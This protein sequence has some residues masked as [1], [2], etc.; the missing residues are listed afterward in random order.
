METRYRRN[1]RLFVAYRAGSS[2]LLYIAIS[3]P[4]YQSFGLNLAQ[5]G[6]AYAINGLTVF[7]FDIP[8]GFVADR[9]GYR[10][11][12]LI[13][14]AL[15]ALG[16]GFLAITYQ[17]WLAYLLQVLLGMGFAI[18]RN[19]DSALA[20]HSADTI[21]A[22]FAPYA[23]LGVAGMGVAEGLASLGTA[24][25]AW[26][27]PGAAPRIAMG[28]QAVVYML[29]L[30]VPWRMYEPR[31]KLAKRLV[32]VRDF[33]RLVRSDLR[34]LGTTVWSEVRSNKEVAW[35]LLYGATIG[36]TTQTVVNLVQPYFQELRL[37]VWQF[38]LWW[39]VYHLLWAACS[40]LSGP[41]EKWL[42]R[43]GAL[44]SLVGWGILTNTAM[45]LMGGTAGL[46]IMVAFYFIRG[47]QMPIIQD[48]MTGVVSQ[49]RRATLLGVM[50]SVQFA[51]YSGM[52]L[53][54]GYIAQVGSVRM[55]FG[56]SAAIYGTLGL[57]FI[58]LLRRRVSS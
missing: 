24:A 25:L 23:R 14:V 18:A 34:A 4:L 47:I 30:I 53:I 41:Y 33:G 31:P 9:Y 45:A 52:N 57:A 26:W 16:F 36:C 12:L 49:D 40:L 13:G 7:L 54:L 3:L 51:M 44:A 58:S 32:T 55:A 48:Y 37:E 2:I 56:V 46:L 17:P 29:L 42:G 21:G 22:A 5:I 1:L 10:R 27:Q 11:M 19:A 50:T 39:A 35:L 6:V 28:L 43:W 38:A 8:A 20:R 15:Q